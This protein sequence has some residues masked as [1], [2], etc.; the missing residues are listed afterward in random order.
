MSED[1]IKWTS[2]GEF[3]MNKESNQKQYFDL[4]L[5]VEC[6]FFEFI[7]KSDYSNGPSTGLAELG[8]YYR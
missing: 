5:D 3:M 7:V 1:G 6:R 8:A 2:V 4:T